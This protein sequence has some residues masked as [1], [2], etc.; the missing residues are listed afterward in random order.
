MRKF[1]V[2]A[3]C[4][5]ALRQGAGQFVVVGGDAVPFV[6]SGHKVDPVAHGRLHDYYHGLAFAP[7]AHC[8]A[9]AFPDKSWFGV[10]KDPAL[11]MARMNALDPGDAE[12]W[13]AMMQRFGKDAPHIFGLLG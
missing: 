10:S 7:A 2:V 9:S 13:D 6:G 8:F 11:T 12:A 3:Q 1:L 4:F 5:W